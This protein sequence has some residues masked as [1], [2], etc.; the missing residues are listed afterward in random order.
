MPGSLIS[1][2]DRM[3]LAEKIQLYRKEA[4]L[5]IVGDLEIQSNTSHCGSDHGSENSEASRRSSNLSNLRER[6]TKALE[7]LRRGSRS[8]AVALACRQNPGPASSSNDF[9]VKNNPCEDPSQGLEEA[10]FPESIP[11]SF[12]ADP[13]VTA[14]KGISQRHIQEYAKLHAKVQELRQEAAHH[15]GELCEVVQAHSEAINA[16]RQREVR[17]CVSI[18]KVI[19]AAFGFT[20][21]VILGFES[22]A[23]RLGA[24]HAI[25]VP[26]QTAKTSLVVHPPQFAM[27]LPGK[28]RRTLPAVHS[29]QFAIQDILIPQVGV[30][31][32]SKKLR[33]MVYER[34][35]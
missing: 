29:P 31:P 6:H 22:V 20:Y 19:A 9:F 30:S 26:G 14:V 7:A 27:V 5:D 23:A 28:A 33:G 16:M 21:G 24:A 4:S 34:R 35:R 15:R 17:P 25:L 1:Q 32:K 2:T 12:T 3:N 8:A 18:I 10:L 13:L 11:T